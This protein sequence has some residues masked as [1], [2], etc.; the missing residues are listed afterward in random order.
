MASASAAGVKL[1]ELG[2]RRATRPDHG[3]RCCQQPA[4]SS[5]AL[6][7]G[8]GDDAVLGTRQEAEQRAVIAWPDVGPRCRPP[9]QWITF[10]RLDFDHVGAAVGKQ[11]R[12]IGACDSD[13]QIDDGVAGQRWLEVD[14]VH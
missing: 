13:R 2:D 11:L 1:V 10:W 4:N 3:V 14:C 9:A 5:H 12:A 6:G 7:L 8:I